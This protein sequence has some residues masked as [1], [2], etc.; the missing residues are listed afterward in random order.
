[1]LINHEIGVIYRWAAIASYLPQRTDNDIKNYWNTHLKKKLRK[2]N[3]DQNQQSSRLDGFTSS[4]SSPE[5]QCSSS[6]GQ[7]ERRLQTNI[8]MAKQAL[9]DALSTM[10][11]KLVSNTPDL[12]E[13]SP[14]NNLKSSHKQGQQPPSSLSLS[15]SSSSS[16][17]ASSTE[18]I[19][20]LLQ[21]W[22]IKSPKKEQSSSISTDHH[23]LCSTMEI[24]YGHEQKPKVNSSEKQVSKTEAF[25][26]LFGTMESSESPYSDFSQAVSPEANFFEHESKPLS[27]GGQGGTLSVLEKWLFDDCSIQHCG[28]QSQ[29]HDL[30]DMPLQETADFV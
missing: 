16:I 7:W 23:S 3:S 20:R 8:H 12:I 17:Y 4:P 21:G 13:S 10:D 28:T 19:A 14:K 26:S 29:V 22:N 1:M 6:R 9:C 30:I 18:N 24:E 15:S 27:D 5:N 25:Q 11:K 2:K